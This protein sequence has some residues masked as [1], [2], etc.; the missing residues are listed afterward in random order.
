MSTPSAEYAA[1]ISPNGRYFAYQSA[2]SGGRFDVY[3]RPYPDV[4][5]GPLADFDRGRSGTCVG[6]VGT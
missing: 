4:S 2:E 6:A 1:N 5:K 3:V